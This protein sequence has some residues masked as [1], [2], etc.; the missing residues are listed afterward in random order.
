[1]ETIKI[2]IEDDE[3]TPISTD[4]IRYD[5]LWTERN[6]LFLREIQDKCNTLSNKH[7]LASHKNKKRYV[8]TAIPAMVLPLILANI[9]LINGFDFKEYINP[10]GM[11]VVGIINGF[12]T[13]LN[14]SKKTQLHNEYAG[15]Y[16]ELS[17]IID[18]TLIRRKKY[19]E[20]FDVLL[21]RFTTHF[22][23]LNSNAPFL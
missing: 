23:N 13:L 17:A 20:P 5:E 19:R 3:N 14:F 22:N 8:K 1:M 2:H 18:K 11:T 15:K 12:Q 9:N 21:E 6:E 16:A 7:D 10:I 4:D